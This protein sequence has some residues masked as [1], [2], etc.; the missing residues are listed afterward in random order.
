[1]TEKRKEKSQAYW[2]ERF[3]QI[4][5]A[6]HAD[7][8]AFIQRAQEAIREA[9]ERIQADIMKWYQRIAD[10][11]EV[12]LSEVRRLLKANELKEFKWSVER[13][14]EAG[15][16]YGVDGSWAKE[17]E[18]A[19][20]KFHITRLESLQ[21][22]IRNSMEQ[23]WAKENAT[24]G[25]AA[26]RAYQEGY[27]RTIFEIQRGVGVGFNVAAIDRRALEKLLARPWAA[28]G[29]NFSDRL[30]TKKEELFNELSR[31]MVRNI[32]LGRPPG[33]IVEAI[34]KKFG[35]EEKNT[36]MYFEAARLVYTESAYFGT[37]SQLEAFEEL[38]AEVA[39]FVATLD[40]RT[41]DECQDADGTIIPIKDVQPGVNAPPL[42]PFC[43]SCLAP[44]YE[45]MAG[46]G[47][48]WARNPETGKGKFI[49]AGMKYADWKREY[50]GK[51]D[52]D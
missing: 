11:N 34:A 21:I 2:N 10:N 6:R 49:P 44:S 31:L 47:T 18:N 20:A 48:R 19:S 45:E 30:W 51:A 15:R 38:D 37:L 14:I 27:Y 42:H 12:S 28:D 41:S 24:V 9:E 7:A 50:V 46:I 36:G 3:A 26:Q 17:L 23:L 40:E 43:R 25:D 4:E 33:E 16:K 8:A 35:S 32:T 13:Y 22:D 5:D 29:E 1:M 39:E 52:A